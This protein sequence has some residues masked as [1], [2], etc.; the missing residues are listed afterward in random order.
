MGNLAASIGPSRPRPTRFVR[1]TQRGQQFAPEGA[2]WQHIQARIDR[3]GR[4][5]CAHVVRIR[6]LEPSGNLLGRAPLGQMH[7]HV[8]PQPG[9]QEF[10]WSPRLTGPTGRQRVAVQAR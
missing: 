2:A 5:L 6:P 1:V 8:L 10:A 7:P 3:L 4:Q 9:G